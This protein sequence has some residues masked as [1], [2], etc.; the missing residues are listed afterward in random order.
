[1]P[2]QARLIHPTGTRVYLRRFVLSG[3]A[4]TCPVQGYHNA[5]ALVDESD[6]PVEAFWEEPANRNPALYQDDA[7]WSTHCTCGYAFTG[8]DE[9]QVNH[10]RRWNTASGLPEPGD[11]FWRED[12]GLSRDRQKWEDTP[13]LYAV[14]PDGRMWDIDSASSNGNGWTR[15]GEPPAITCSPSIWTDTEK[16]YHGFLQGGVWTDDLSGKV[17]DAKPYGYM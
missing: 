5:E 3:D 12:G 9:R 7:R 8:D 14:C 15:T 10:V 16:G 6:E 1:M 17:F 4:E 13:H 11:M 2:V